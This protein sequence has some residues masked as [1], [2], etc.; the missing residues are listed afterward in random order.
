MGAAPASDTPDGRPLERPLLYLDL[1]VD[2]QTPDPRPRVSV[3]R[4][5]PGRNTYDTEDISTYLVEDVCTFVLHSFGSKSPPFD[6]TPEDVSTHT[7]H[8]K[9]DHIFDAS[10]A[11]AVLLTVYETYWVGLLTP[12]WE[13]GVRSRLFS[14]AHPVVLIF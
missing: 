14:L 3:L 5:K 7:A 4:Y 1:S 12:S 10:A 11:E 6:V 13:K 8:R 9:A 2:A